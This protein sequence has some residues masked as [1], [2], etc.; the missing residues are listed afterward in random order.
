MQGTRLYRKWRPARA[1]GALRIERVTLV[2]SYH[3]WG[4]RVNQ[5]GVPGTQKCVGR[6][7]PGPSSLWEWAAAGNWNQLLLPGGEKS[8]CR[9]QSAGSQKE[10]TRSFPPL[11][12]MLFEAVQPL[13]QTTQGWHISNGYAL[14]PEVLGII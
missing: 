13:P 4:L 12:D 9:E 11:L 5:V 2:S 3:P 14:F 6:D 7:I 1:K 8:C 10:E